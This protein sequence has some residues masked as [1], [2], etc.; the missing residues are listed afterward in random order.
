MKLYKVKTQGGKMKKINK[1]I[2]TQEDQQQLTYFV[3]T[4]YCAVQLILPLPLYFNHLFQK[5]IFIPQH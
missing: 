4:I 2:D 3:G 1:Y 5:D